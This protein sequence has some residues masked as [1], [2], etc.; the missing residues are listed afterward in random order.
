MAKKQAK[1]KDKFIRI[2]KRLYVKLW[3]VARKRKEPTS[4]AEV[5]REILDKALK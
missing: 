2:P 3:K 5:A 4:P 1:E